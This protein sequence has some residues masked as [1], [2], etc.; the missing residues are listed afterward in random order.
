MLYDVEPSTELTGGP[1]FNDNEF[2]Y[3]FIG[4]LSKACL[5]F[6]QSKSFPKNKEAIF[7]SDYANYA[8]LEQIH[9]FITENGITNVDLSVDD[10][11]SLLESLIYDGKIE[12][13]LGSIATDDGDLEFSY[14]AVHS[15]AIENYCAQIPCGVCPVVSSCSDHGPITPSSCDYFKNWFSF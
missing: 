9:R 12:K 4:E 11:S 2:D 13:I 7:P 5:K 8:T 14:R 15:E 10:I 6:V 1:W 3:E